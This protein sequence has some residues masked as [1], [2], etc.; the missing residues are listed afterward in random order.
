MEEFLGQIKRIRKEKGLSQADLAEQ[1]GVP[2]STIGRLES[3]KTF[4][5]LKTLQKIAEVLDAEIYLG[6][7]DSRSPY[8]KRWDNL[9][10]T[11]YWK[12][13]PVSDVCVRGNNVF[14]KRYVKHP[15]KQ[16]FY[17]DKMD[18]FRLTEILKTRCWQ[19]DRADVDLILKKLGIEYYDP[20]EI[21]KKTHGI[22]YNDFLW[23]QFNGEFLQW[24]DVAPRRFRNE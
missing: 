13:E 9:R 7:K 19:E 21:V 11:C 16:M 12:D 23:F 14:V 6:K 5:N 10:F 22:S 15:V 24:K 8:L 1:V 20:L 3:R 17:A 2:Q 18:L 4:P